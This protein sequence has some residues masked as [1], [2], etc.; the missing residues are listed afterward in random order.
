MRQYIHAGSYGAATLCSRPWPRYDFIHYTPSSLSMDQLQ[1]DLGQSDTELA[2]T[3]CHWVTLPLHSDLRHGSASL[4][5]IMHTFST[6]FGPANICFNES[7][8]YIMLCVLCHV[9]S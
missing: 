1:C 4:D 8:E 5:H 2:T 7:L 6:H 3:H 9:D